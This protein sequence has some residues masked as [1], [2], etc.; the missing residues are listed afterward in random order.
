MKVAISSKTPVH[1]SVTLHPNKA[2]IFP[3]QLTHR[4]R[5]II[6]K[7][8]FRYDSNSSIPPKNVSSWC[9]V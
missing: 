7:S 9:W 8:Q 2:S 5:E 4:K 3:A 6:M 1:S